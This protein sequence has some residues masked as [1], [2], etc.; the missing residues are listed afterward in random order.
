ME[1]KYNLK[2][3]FTEFFLSNLY[4]FI[5][6]LLYFTLRTYLIENKVN[7]VDLSISLIL[8]IFKIFINNI[9]T[10]FK[11]YFIFPLFLIVPFFYG[12]FICLIIISNNIFLRR[13]RNLLLTLIFTMFY[14]STY[15]TLSFAAL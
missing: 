13:N 7:N 9:Y 10:A 1:S 3:N 8:T 5:I 15:K 14:I 2:I 11:L 4:G 6:A 12:F